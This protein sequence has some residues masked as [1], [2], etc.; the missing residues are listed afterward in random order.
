MC[1]V[2]D[3][4]ESCQYVVHRQICELTI[5]QLHNCKTP[6]VSQYEVFENVLPKDCTQCT[7]RKLK[8]FAHL[9]VTCQSIQFGNESVLPQL[10]FGSTQNYADRAEHVRRSRRW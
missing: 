4:Q 7:C 2:L 8:S 10:N 1:Q 6:V 9:E 3:D 5:A